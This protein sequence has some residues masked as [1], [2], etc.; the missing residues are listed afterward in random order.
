MQKIKYPL[1]LLTFTTLLFV[2]ELFN[3]TSLG[4]LI[5]NFFPC[6]QIP[7]N[8]APC[9]LQYDI[10]FS[11]FLIIIFL[12]TLITIMIRLIKIYDSRNP[13]QNSTQ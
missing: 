9:Y 2:L 6:E 12:A 13:S 7:Q 4:S 1:I 8:S 5:N 10:Y 11:I 3:K